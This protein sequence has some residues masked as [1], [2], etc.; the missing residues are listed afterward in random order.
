MKKKILALA[1]ALISVGTFSIFAADGGDNKTDRQQCDRQ[2]SECKS[3]RKCINPF[4]GLDL[5]ADQQAKIQ[6]LRPE[7]CKAGKGAKAGAK[8]DGSQ[9]GDRNG[10]DKGVDRRQAKRDYLAKVKDILTPE[11]YV[12][13]LENS[14]TEAPRM[15]RAHRSGRPGD[16]KGMRQ[17]RGDRQQN[18]KAEK[19]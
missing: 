14:F 1:V 5:T 10:N 11:Q 19:K 13:F 18:A 9:K 16:N 3:D 12:I 7:G 17:P 6:A 2:K 4:D 15:D 8:C